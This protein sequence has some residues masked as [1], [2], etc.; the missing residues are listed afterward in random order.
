MLNVGWSFS[1]TTTFSQPT[2]PCFMSNVGMP[3]PSGQLQSME[4]GQHQPLGLWHRP[5][6][7]VS[8]TY[9]LPVPRQLPVLP[10]HWNSPLASPITFQPGGFQVTTPV[11]RRPPRFQVLTPVRV[12]PPLPLS[13]VC[14]DDA[15]ATP[16]G[17]L[18]GD[19]MPQLLNADDNDTDDVNY[20]VG[21]M[22]KASFQQVLEHA[23]TGEMDSIYTSGMDDQ[24]EM[25]P[26][27][28]GPRAPFSFFGSNGKLKRLSGKTTVPDPIA[29]C[30]CWEP[31]VS[32]F[33][34]Q[35]LLTKA[36]GLSAFD[37]DAVLL[38][39]RVDMFIDFDKS[40][41]GFAAALWPDLIDKS[42][43]ELKGLTLKNK[44][45]SLGI[46]CKVIRTLM[47]GSLLQF[48]EGWAGSARTTYWHLMFGFRCAC[49]DYNFTDKHNV[50][51]P[52]GLRLW[53]WA[54]CESEEG[55]TNWWGTQ[56]S[57]YL[58]CC[59]SKSKRNETNQ[60][61]GDQTRK[62]VRTGNAQQVALSLL[63]FL[64]WL[65]SNEPLLEQPGSS[66]LA[67]I[68][69]FK[70]VKDFV[71]ASCSRLALGSYQATSLKPLQI[72]HLSKDWIELKKPYP[73][74]AVRQKLERLASQSTS[75]KTRKR[76][77]NG[78][79]N[80]MKQSQVYPHPFCKLVATISKRRLHNS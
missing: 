57:S 23:N 25:S 1:N 21:K 6:F 64:S 50:L 48:I 9:Q 30:K 61:W 35:D 58:N 46:R 42:V 59:L 63:Y 53:M 44:L 18:N 52:L 60:F 55:S 47:H 17:S 28:E 4:V 36:G 49:F 29:D 76:Q 74:K 70:T 8:M 33:M 77:Y 65:F 20:N 67:K 14:A 26:M 56:C 12:R 78:K 54:L 71:G 2:Y 24:P 75:K 7:S 69:P 79:K 66:C 62:F 40:R 80:K 68:P 37:T 38:E 10:F 15:D 39:K 13:N 5:V 73:D 11:W 34:S 19:E 32:P 31:M 72:W 22:G 41:K 16:P 43:H 3:L 27:V 45:V 51:S